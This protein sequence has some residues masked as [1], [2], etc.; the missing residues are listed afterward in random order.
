MTDLERF[1]THVQVDPTTG[2]HNWKDARND[3][4][5]GQFSVRRSKAERSHCPR[6]GNKRVQAHKWI[7]EFYH[8]Q[9]EKGLEVDHKCCNPSCVNVAHLQALTKAK[10]LELRGAVHF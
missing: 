1:Q 5:Y 6:G 9:V 10:N 2:C 7:F 3:K 4:G 8:G